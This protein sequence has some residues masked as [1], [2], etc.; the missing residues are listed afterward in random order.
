MV[1]VK[2]KRAAENLE[3]AVMQSYLSSIENKRKR[4][5]S[6]VDLTPGKHVIIKVHSFFTY[7]KGA[8]YEDRKEAGRGKDDI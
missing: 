4:K 3:I 2:G 8:G 1:H 6:A 5:A 7:M